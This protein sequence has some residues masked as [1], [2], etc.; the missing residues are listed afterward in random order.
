MTFVSFVGY[1]YGM[2]DIAISPVVKDLLAYSEDEYGKQ[3]QML[4]FIRQENVSH[5]DDKL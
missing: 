3:L 2:S 5:N 1:R 4:G